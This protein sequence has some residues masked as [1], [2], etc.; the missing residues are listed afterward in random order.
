MGSTWRVKKML[1]VALSE[2]EF[3]A[4]GEDPLPEVSTEEVRRRGHKYLAKLPESA[5]TGHMTRLFDLYMA[6]TPLCEAADQAGECAGFPQFPGDVGDAGADGRRAA[7]AGAEGDGAQDDGHRAETLFPAG[8]RGVP[9][10]AANGHAEA[11]D[12]GIS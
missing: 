6:G 8:P 11:A 3:T 9:A 5:K 2:G 1:A 12:R 7:G 4:D 10:G